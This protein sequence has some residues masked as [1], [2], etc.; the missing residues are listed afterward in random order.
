M[1]VVEPAAFSL[2]SIA[3]RPPMLTVEPDIRVPLAEF[4]F[5]F[6]R[7]AGPGGQNVNK[8]NTKA[9]L[10]WP[11]AVS[12]SVTDGLRRR[13]RAKYGNRLTTEGELVLSSQPFGDQSRKKA[14]CLEK[15]QGMLASVARPP[16]KRRRTRPT[17]AS[18]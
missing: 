5:S 10:R 14:D 16:V 6:V 18:K 3:S 4:Q 7:S 17:K 15:L 1:S 2:Q 12:P 8:V 13:F 11:L 9:V